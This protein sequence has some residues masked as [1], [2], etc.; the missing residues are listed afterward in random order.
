MRA[1]I[2]IAAAA[3]MLAAS[4]ALAVTYESAS[5]SGI[6]ASRFAERMPH[7]VS[8][9][10]NLEE[11]VLGFGA[12]SAATVT[13]RV[14]VRAPVVTGYDDDIAQPRI[15]GTYDPNPTFDSYYTPAH[16]AGSTAAPAA[17]AEPKLP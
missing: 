2:K 12:G 16:A 14:V 3:V 7:F 13:S 8:L 10:G 6:P 11:S 5:M 4:P 1:M 17:G 9:Y 15:G